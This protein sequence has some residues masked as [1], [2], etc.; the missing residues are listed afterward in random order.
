MENLKVPYAADSEDKL[1]SPLEATKGEQYFC[2]LCKSL[3]I[4][5]RGPIKTPHFAHKPS[6][7]CSS[8]TRAHKIAKQLIIQSVHNWKRRISPSPRIIR[9]CKICNST[10]EQMLPDKLTH[11]VEERT[12]EGG[13]IV[14]VALMKLNQPIAAI[15]V[16]ATHKIGIYKRNMLELP[17][18]EVDAYSI[19]DDPM[20][21]N[22]EY[23]NFHHVRCGKCKRN[24]RKMRAV[25]KDRIASRLKQFQLKEWI[26]DHFGIS[27]ISELDIFEDR[28]GMRIH[29]EDLRL[30]AEGAIYA[31]F[32]QNPARNKP[33][34]F[35]GDIEPM[36]A[37]WELSSTYDAQKFYSFM[38]HLEN[39]G[40]VERVPSSFQWQAKASS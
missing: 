31:K 12:V 14:D 38:K 26:I 17:F 6:E 29:E 22:P 32:I 7:N 40:I 21:W 24:R 35:D 19:I 33:F 9:K 3:L 18:I 28:T 37:S 16:R 8:E 36:L 34:S 10:I 39:K 13:F 23:D 5:R 2:P 25:P 27:D 30:T 15:E 20:L 1:I 4:F 11:A